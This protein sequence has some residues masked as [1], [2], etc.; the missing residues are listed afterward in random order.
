MGRPK[1]MHNLMERI[2]KGIKPVSTNES[3]S[4]MEFDI[5]DDAV[6]AW[7]EMYGQPPNQESFSKF[8]NVVLTKYLDVKKTR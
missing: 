1:N 6:S 8:I 2:V 4:T 3:S 5:S 7:T